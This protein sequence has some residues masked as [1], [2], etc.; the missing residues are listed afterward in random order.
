MPDLV[1]KSDLVMDFALVIQKKRFFT[2]RNPN[3]IRYSH[4]FS[5]NDVADIPH[6]EIGDEG[7]FIQVQGIDLY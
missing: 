5:Y 7:R 1:R 4:L 6:A 3:A 2:T